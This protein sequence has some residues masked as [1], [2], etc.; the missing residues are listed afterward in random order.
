MKEIIQGFPPVSLACCIDVFTVF[1]AGQK[2]SCKSN[3]ADI[4]ARHYVGCDIQIITTYL[5]KGIH[6]YAQMNRLLV[7]KEYIIVFV[8]IISAIIHHTVRIATSKRFAKEC[9][10]TRTVGLQPRP[11]GIVINFIYSNHV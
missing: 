7:K 11:K 4:H 2:I 6:V 10:K 8:Y 5:S 9:S 3:V 1:L